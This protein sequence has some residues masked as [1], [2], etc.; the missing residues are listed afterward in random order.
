MKSFLEQY[1]YDPDTTDTFA[2]LL[3]KELAFN[4]TSLVDH[5]RLARLLYLTWAVMILLAYVTFKT[6]DK[7]RAV[8]LFLVAS[9]LGFFLEYWGAT[10][11]CWIYY[12]RETPHFA[13]QSSSRIACWCGR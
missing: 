13:D 7:R 6:N 10:R 1:K 3:K 11:Y 8:L 12:T 4:R 5:P 9:A 2:E